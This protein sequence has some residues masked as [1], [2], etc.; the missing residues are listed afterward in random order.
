MSAINVPLPGGRDITEAALRGGINAVLGVLGSRR[1]DA[2]TATQGARARFDAATEN[3]NVRILKEAFRSTGRHDAEGQTPFI[4]G[5]LRHI[6]NEVLREQ[7]PIRNGL[8]IF[9]TDGSVPVG[10]RTHTVRRLKDRAEVRV[11]RAGQG[12]LPKSSLKQIEQEFPVRHYVTAISWDIF[13]EQSAGFAN[14]PL[15]RELMASARDAIE[16]FANDKIWYGDDDH[17]IFGILN[18]PWLAKLISLVPFT[19]EAPADSRVQLREM[20]R[21]V[22]YAP[23]ASKQTF[24][25]DT[26]ACSPRWYDYVSQTVMGTTSTQ[27]DRTIL[28]AFMAAH[29][30]MKFEKCWELQDV[31]G[32]GVDGIFLYRNARQAIA[33]VIPM[34][35]ATLPLHREHF[36]MSQ[37]MFMSHGGIVMRDVGHNLLVYVEVPEN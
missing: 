4:A 2:K 34:D 16:D 26:I 1:N 28:E 12:P 33:N 20:N 32:P 24:R 21:W 19:E 17:G 23:Q 5:Q 27:R 35:I 7:R 8:R 9:P 15:I 37:P 31:G 6:Y 30:E 13:E 29:P 3:L 25:P 10:A 11:H 14:F 18:Y 36:E 22:N